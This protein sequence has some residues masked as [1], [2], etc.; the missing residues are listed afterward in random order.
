MCCV[1]RLQQDVLQ[2]AR[3]EGNRIGHLQNEL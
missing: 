2:E 1:L 3:K